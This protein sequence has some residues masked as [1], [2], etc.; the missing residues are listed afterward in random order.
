MITRRILSISSDVSL[1]LFFFPPSFVFVPRAQM[2][3]AGT[4]VWIYLNQMLGGKEKLMR[5][6]GGAWSWE[7]EYE[8]VKCLS[9]I[10]TKMA[11]VDRHASHS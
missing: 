6:F 10:I 8:G 9:E 3:H 1:F 2:M 7:E 5:F 11:N 4:N